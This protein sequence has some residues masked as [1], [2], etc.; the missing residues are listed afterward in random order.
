[1]PQF[2]HNVISL[3]P[4]VV[5]AI[6]GLVLGI[7]F[8]RRARKAANLVLIASVL[9]LLQAGFQ[10][11]ST[12]VLLP[13]SGSGGLSWEAYSILSSAVYFV[14][15]SS[16]TGLLLAAA[17]VERPAAPAPAT[18]IEGEPEPHRGTLVLVLGLVGMLVFSPL[19]IVAWVLGV[20][21]LRAMDQGRRDAAGRGMTLAGLIFGI[22]ATL[23][24]I[25]F[26]CLAALYVYAFLNSSG[27]RY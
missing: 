15:G 19:G 2:L 24:L 16:I 11:F 3:I 27:W 9:L 8:Q 26:V 21:E 14:L 10:L 7:T 17:F 25:V 4:V 6:I 23:M 20:Q 13:N 5:P 1:M 22:L 12:L 18:P